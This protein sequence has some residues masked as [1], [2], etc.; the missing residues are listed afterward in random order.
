[1]L[2]LAD[3]IAGERLTFYYVENPSDLIDVAEF[4]RARKTLAWD[5]ESTG[6][7]CYHPDWQLRT[8]QLGNATASYVVPAKYRKF[9]AWLFRQ[10]VNWIGHNGPHDVRSVDAHLGF[11]T[12][13]E[14][15]ADTSII[16]HHLDSRNRSEGGVGH[17]LKELS[18]AYVD[19]EAGKW[20]VALKR[21]FKTI[22]VALPGEVYKSGKFKGQPKTRA[23][24]LSEGWSLIDPTNSTYIAYA[25]SDPILTFRLFRRLKS[26]YT[27]YQELYAFDSRVQWACDRLQRRAIPLDVAYTE[28]LGNAYLY[29]ASILQEIAAGYGCAN[30]NST[31]QLATVLQSLGAVL[32][33]RTDKGALK[34]DGRILR[35]FL[36]QGGKLAEFCRAVLGAK[37]LLKRKK[38]YTDQMLE[39]RDINDRV[40]PSINP[41]GARTARMSVSNPPLQQL[42][43][44]D[45]ESELGD[46]D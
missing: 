27:Q 41:L 20:E 9:I 25:A 19:R 46:E 14:C 29:R 32:T 5:T 39:E 38:N 8:V 22:R 45:N 40:H 35:S 42:P 12:G 33:E 30:I 24:H 37:Q 11:D 31:A 23:A 15:R 1:M 6:L 21:E 28:R 36:D 7:N 17:G 26:V 43:T 10:P 34:V 4:V 16:S 13:V 44:K 3:T 18:I 2:R